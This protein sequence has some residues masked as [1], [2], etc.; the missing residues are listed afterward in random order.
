MEENPYKSAT[1]THLAKV[2]GERTAG[3]RPFVIAGW[4]AGF[5]SLTAL[6]L[7]PIELPGSWIYYTFIGGNAACWFSI[8]AARSPW[9]WKVTLAV[10]TSIGMLMEVLVIG[11]AAIMANGLQGTQ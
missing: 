9:Y 7:L 3:R 11:V 1:A 6:H 8:A 4:L 5:F 10:L 2:S